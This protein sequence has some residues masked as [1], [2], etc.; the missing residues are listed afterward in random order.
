MSGKTSWFWAILGVVCICAGAELTFTGTGSYL[1]PSSW[2]GGALPGAGD[3]VLVAPGATLTLDGTPAQPQTVAELAVARDNTGLAAATFNL[4]GTALNA[5]A[6]TVGSRGTVRVGGGG[7]LNVRRLAKQRIS[8][9]YV[10]DG[11]TLGVRGSGGTLAS[12][13]DNDT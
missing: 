8:G 9:S 12:Y 7:R 6:V 4:S 2:P 10:F 1:T 5:D 11:A 3:T 13:F